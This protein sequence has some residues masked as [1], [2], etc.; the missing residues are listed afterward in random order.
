MCPATRIVRRCVCRYGPLIV[1]LPGDRRLDRQRRD[2]ALVGA[3]DD[4]QPAVVDLERDPRLASRAPFCPTM[5]GVQPQRLGAEVLACVECGV[6]AVGRSSVKLVT[7][8]SG[9]ASNVVVILPP[10]IVIVPLS[11]T[12]TPCPSSTTSIDGSLLPRATR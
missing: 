3:L 9:T 12:V 6:R 1:T 8:T 11:F 7:G 2:G 4:L 5:V 10:V